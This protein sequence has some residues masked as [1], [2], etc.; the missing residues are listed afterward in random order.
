MPSS[1]NLTNF[2]QIRDRISEKLN[3]TASPISNIAYSED[4]LLKVNR[5]KGEHNPFMVGVE[6]EVSTK[7][8]M[9]QMAKAQEVPFFIGKDDGS[10]SGKFSNCIELVTIPMSIAAQKKHW[11]HFFSNVDYEKFDCSTKTN[12]G[13]HIH[14]GRD[15]LEPYHMKNIAYFMAHPNNKEFLHI[16][17]E[18]HT[19]T[20]YAKFPTFERNISNV[21][22]FKNCESSLRSLGKYSI[23]NFTSGKPTIE[24]RLFKGIVSYASVA[25]ALDFVQALVTWTHEP[26]FFT[27]ITLANFLEYLRKS[28]KNR[29]IA[30]KEFL[31]EDNT[32][33]LAEEGR[34]IN[35]L[36]QFISQN[37]NKP[38]EIVSYVLR[39]FDSVDKN[40]M[41]ILNTS[42]DDF[43]FFINAI[44]DLSFIDK[45][46]TPLASK[47][48]EFEQRILGKF[49]NKTS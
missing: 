3:Y 28:P 35:E 41:S 19:E 11:A 37:L 43:R 45:T 36:G 33:S 30:L 44:G 7:Y 20:Q 25:K 48:R 42:C 34:K 4:D 21:K 14:V 46:S 16:L 23:L 29:Y 26:T 2:P 13:L 47:N 10:I 31:K 39:H 27:D 5:L 22:V 40:L 12:N 17:S 9:A 18:R 15:M 38:K 6:L 49:R 1:P 8:T 32:F 24:F